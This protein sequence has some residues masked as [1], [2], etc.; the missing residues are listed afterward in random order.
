MQ[1]RQRVQRR[2]QQIAVAAQIV[3]HRVTPGHS[4][5]VGGGH[6]GITQHVDMRHDAGHGTL[7]T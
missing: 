7:E 1:V 3:L 6:G 5:T 4:V 2:Q